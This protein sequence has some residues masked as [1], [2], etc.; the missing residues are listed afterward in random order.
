MKV[1][2]SV[3]LDDGT[4]LAVPVNVNSGGNSAFW[5]AGLLR[6]ATAA[7]NRLALAVI[8]MYG[9]RA[10]GIHIVGDAAA[11]DPIDVEVVPSGR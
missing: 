9:G 7:A 4:Q 11:T 8:A 5:A 1:Q 2:V 10:G 6:G 3:W